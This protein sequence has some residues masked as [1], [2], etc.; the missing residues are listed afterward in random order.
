[1]V[2]KFPLIVIYYTVRLFVLCSL[3]DPMIQ[4]DLIFYPLLLFIFA[5]QFVVCESLLPAIRGYFVYIFRDQLMFTCCGDI[6]VLLKEKT[7]KKLT[8]D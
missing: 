7:N 3:H 6:F 2:C 4:C 8:H 1:M 5:Y